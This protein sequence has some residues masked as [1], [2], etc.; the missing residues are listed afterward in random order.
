M[1]QDKHLKSFLNS[2]FILFDSIFVQIYYLPQFHQI[3][4]KK[5]HPLKAIQELLGMPNEKGTSWEF[6]GVRPKT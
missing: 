1:L 4:K 6:Q 3:G 5:S 2:L